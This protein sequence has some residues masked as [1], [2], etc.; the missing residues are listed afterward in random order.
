[1]S[2]MSGDSLRV[3]RGFVSAANAQ[4]RAA[5]LGEHQMRVTK[6]GQVTTPSVVAELKA[7]AAALPASGSSNGSAQATR[8]ASTIGAP[9]ATSLQ[10]SGSDAFRITWGA[11]QGATRYGIW[12]NGAL[13][14]YVTDP[15]FAGNLAAGSSGTIQV[16]AVLATGAHSAKSAALAVSRAGSAAI[17]FAGPMAETAA[18]AQA[19]SAASTAA[20][21]PAPA[22][23]SDASGAT[24]PS[25][26]TS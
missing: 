13:L 4:L 10:S 5:G 1:M 16:D 15:R 23:S 2:D 18:A 20:A 22:A 21:A 7:K 26:A 9:V 6:G 11:V 12:Q 17:A 14:G 24:A 19:A 8:G 3:L 25:G